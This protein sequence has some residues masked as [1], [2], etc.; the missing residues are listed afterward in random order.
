ML[1]VPFIARNPTRLQHTM[2]KFCANLT[3]LWNEVPFLDRFALAARAGFTG[4]E[5]LFP[6]EH[7]AHQLAEKLARCGGF[8]DRHLVVQSH[9]IGWT[10]EP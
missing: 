1:R 2:P 9:A 5:Y 6:Y 8:S 7:D 4:V 3:L 10:A